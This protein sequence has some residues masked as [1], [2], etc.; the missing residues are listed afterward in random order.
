M[1]GQKAQTLSAVITS[2]LNL[3]LCPTWFRDW[4]ILNLMIC[5]LPRCIFKGSMWQIWVTSYAALS[6]L[7]LCVRTPRLCMKCSLHQD[8]QSGVAFTDY[9]KIFWFFQLE[10]EP[11]FQEQWQKCCSYHGIMSN[12]FCWEEIHGHW[13]TVEF[14]CMMHTFN[15]LHDSNGMSLT[16]SWIPINLTGENVARYFG[17]PIECSSQAR[18]V[19]R[20][21]D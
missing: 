1:I 2:D 21:W 5:W 6:L 15:A 10:K 14:G 11:I 3:C 8:K 16:R 19:W 18:W 4:F 9:S 7:E 20:L 13:I 12:A 17:V